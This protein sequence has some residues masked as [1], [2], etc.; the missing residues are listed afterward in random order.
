MNA[1]KVMIRQRG[2]VRNLE[3]PLQIKIARADVEGAV[4]CVA[5][6]HLMPFERSVEPTYSILPSNEPLSLP[7]TMQS[8]LAEGNICTKLRDI[9]I[10]LLSLSRA[11]EYAFHNKDISLNPQALDEDF[12]EV[13]HRLLLWVNTKHSD[14]DEACRLGGLVYSKCITRSVKSI[15]A[16]LRP[17]VQQLMAKITDI[18]P[19]PGTVP[20][21]IWLCYVGAISVCI[22]SSQRAWFVHYIAGL[23]GLNS[24]FSTWEGMKYFLSDMLWV[25][26]V[27]VEPFKKVWTEVEAVTLASTGS[28]RSSSLNLILERP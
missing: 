28:S 14:L 24:R 19:Q 26:K 22:Y 4:N 2:G 15:S 25:E 9:F 13:Q 10:H 27:H 11:I 6:P 20:L 12:V 16:R 17:V 7:G 5:L 18:V 1:M 3:G 8:S 21:L 23:T